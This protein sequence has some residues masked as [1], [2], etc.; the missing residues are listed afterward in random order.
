MCRRISFSF[1]NHRFEKEENLAEKGWWFREIQNIFLK[2]SWDVGAD[3][4]D[5]RHLHIFCT[6]NVSLRPGRIHDWTNFS[7]VRLNGSGSD[8]CTKKI[9][10]SSVRT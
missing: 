8:G 7:K 4:L 1:L 10:K 3:H 2:T 9:P 5:R 6:T